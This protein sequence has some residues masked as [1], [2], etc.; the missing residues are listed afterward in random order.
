MACGVPAVVSD[1]PVLRE[2][3]D[4]AACFADPKDPVS[5]FNAFKMLEN[6]VKY[7][8]FVNKGLQRSGQFQNDSAWVEHVADIKYLMQNA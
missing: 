1:I 6:Q 8:E 3:N 2:I 7:D 4:C 5:W